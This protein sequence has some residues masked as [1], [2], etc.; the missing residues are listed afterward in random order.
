MRVL[1]L[2]LPE[3]SLAKLSILYT[4]SSKEKKRNYAFYLFNQWMLNRELRPTNL[5]IWWDLELI[6]FKEVS[7]ICRWTA[8]NVV[9][10]MKKQR[11]YKKKLHQVY[12][13]CIFRP[14]QKESS[15][16]RWAW[17]FSVSSLSFSTIVPFY[18]NKKGKYNK[19]YVIYPIS[20]TLQIILNIE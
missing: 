18:Q 12:K 11:T 17:S 16:L 10:E 1:K 2:S 3:N 19:G 13:V 15:S 4:K 7:P 9:Y 14:S 20:I 8:G 5:S 6:S